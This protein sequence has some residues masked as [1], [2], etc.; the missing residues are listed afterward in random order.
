M[1][2]SCESW[3][4]P[5]HWRARWSRSRL[6][7]RASSH[8]DP[9]VNRGTPG[10]P[11]LGGTDRRPRSSRT[12]PDP[13]RR[14]PIGRCAWGKRLLKTARCQPTRRRVGMGSRLL[15]CGSNRF[16]TRCVTANSPPHSSTRSGAGWE[17]LLSC[18]KSLRMPKPP[19]RNY[20]PRGRRLP[21]ALSVRPPCAQ[22]RNSGSRPIRSATSRPRRCRGPVP[23]AVREAL[24]PHLPRAGRPE[25]R[26]HGA[27]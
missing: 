8:C 23:G 27:R 12:S 18:R 4:R 3:R 9:S 7:R 16:A 2:T 24:I 5:L 15:A 11:H 26:D 14:R 13:P 20:V 17:N 1:P 21:S 6:W 25:A 19:H 10:S 22:P